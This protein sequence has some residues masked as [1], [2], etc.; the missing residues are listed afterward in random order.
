MA[1]WK[2]TVYLRRYKCFVHISKGFVFFFL[3]RNFIITCI[4]QIYEVCILFIIRKYEIPVQEYHKTDC[5]WE[6]FV[7]C[8]FSQH[9]FFFE[10]SK[11]CDSHEIKHWLRNPMP[12]S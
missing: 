3:R 4:F 8:N 12:K 11:F 7:I 10:N 9:F 5:H 2:I 6:N 1:K